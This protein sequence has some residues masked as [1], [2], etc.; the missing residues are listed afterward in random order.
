MEQYEKNYADYEADY[1]GIM[2]D[3][4]EKGKEEHGELKV[5]KVEDHKEEKKEL[6]VE[7]VE[8]HKEEKKELKVEKVEDHKEEKKEV[9][10]VEDKK[11][12]NVV[13]PNE[14]AQAMGNAA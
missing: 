14:H 13:V 1:D 7:K 5:E 12:E 9:E 8:D 2:N 10:K 6:K 4:E 3:D 11:N